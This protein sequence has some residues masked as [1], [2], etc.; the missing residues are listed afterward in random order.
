MKIV[1]LNT[2]TQ[3]GAAEAALRLH[4]ALMQEK[5][6]SKFVALYK[7]R[8]SI[9]GVSDFRDG[10]NP[11]NFWF[12][13][14]K[15][16]QRTINTLRIS[17]KSGELFSEI[18]SVWKAEQNSEV[19]TADIVHLHWVSNFV[20]L[21]S[22]F[23]NKF[24]R[25]GGFPKIVWTIHDHFLFAGGFHYPPIRKGSVSE[26]KIQEQK[27]IV[28]A[29]LSEY[30]IDIVCP[31]EHLRTLAQNSGVL[32]KCTFHVIKNPVDTEVF[33]QLSKEECR[34]K[35][36]IPSDKKV[37][38]F[39][40]D[41]I[42]YERKGF[43]LLEKALSLLENDVTLIV[44]GTGQLPDKI[45]KATVKHFGLVKDKTLLNELYG[46]CDVMVNPSLDDISSNTV[47]EAMACGRP[48][49]AF[50]TGGIPELVAETNGLI[51]K[52]KTAIE[53]ANTINAI[54]KM[55]FDP[56]AI[57][58]KALKEHSFSVIAEK[59]LAVYNKVK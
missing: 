54:L 19:R 55:N 53:L 10:L 32:S 22:F 2:Y 16:K 9:N 58:T 50:K 25:S 45:G 56:A 3:G 18:S 36:N 34:T 24:P 44:A 28:K 13:K 43:P 31:S 48:V 11:I 17:E 26:D 41:R 27:N 33:K 1:H 8:C 7:G 21:P 15:N 29:L 59:Y 40:S 51:A 49:V 4:S 5:I 46:A 38:F 52:D 23:K 14:I 42:E 39:I 30:P 47:I 12:S 37:L 20:D 57:N 6:E 35:L